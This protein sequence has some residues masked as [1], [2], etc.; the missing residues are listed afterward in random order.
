MKCPNCG[1][2]LKT[3]A[4]FCPS[5]GKAVAVTTPTSAPTSP[6]KPT[7]VS[8]VQP[9][10]KQN[11]G[12]TVSI[13]TQDLKNQAKNYWSYFVEGLKAPS[14]TLTQSNNW[15]GYIQ[16]IILNVLIA[17][18]PTHYFAL[19]MNTLEMAKKS[20]YGGDE[21]ATVVG[22]MAKRIGVGSSVPEFFFRMFIYSLIFSV[23]YVLV[24]FLIVRG[25]M[26]NEVSLGQYTTRFGGLLSIEIAILLLADIILQVSSAGNWILVLVLILLASMVFSAA[27]NAVILLHDNHSSI[28]KFHLL[29]V[30]LVIVMVLIYVVAQIGGI[31]LV[32]NISSMYR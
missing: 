1:S 28:N 9:M 11:A 30:A 31:N 4:K 19:A 23:I 20:L 2:Q 18:I 7:P 17:F 5:C 12:T 10:A 15:F 27:F 8:P 25:I 16:F 21:V 13:D 29:L 6:V 3:G 14:T 32:S 24:G 22:E 26:K